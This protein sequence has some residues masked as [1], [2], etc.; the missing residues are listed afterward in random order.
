MK[1]HVEPWPTPQTV[2]SKAAGMIVAIPTKFS[3]SS[4]CHGFGV[5]D[6][7]VSSC[8]DNVFEEHGLTEDGKTV[9]PRIPATVP[10]IRPNS[11]FAQGPTS[12]IRFPS[13]SR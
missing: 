1:I 13:G 4:G 10:L 5:F 7:A 12:S 9:A 8:F 2:L 3:R 11:Y 6:K